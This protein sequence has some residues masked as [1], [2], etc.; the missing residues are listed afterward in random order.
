MID[1]S[2]SGGS[3]AGLQV[4]ADNSS[5]PSDRASNTSSPTQPNT[6]TTLTLPLPPNDSSSGPTGH[7]SNGAS[8]ALPAAKVQ[9]GM[10]RIFGRSDSNTGPLSSAGHESREGGISISFFPSDGRQHGTIC[11]PG[12]EYVVLNTLYLTFGRI[13]R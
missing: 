9:S 10:H 13:N 1:D 3:T 12:P 11:L 4:L 2:V 8:M 6:P 7:N 5:T